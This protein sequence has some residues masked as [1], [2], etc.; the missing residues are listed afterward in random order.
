M[1][2]KIILHIRYLKKG[3]ERGKEKKGGR[4]N[5]DGNLSWEK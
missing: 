1:F 4:K 5:A 3:V 2:L